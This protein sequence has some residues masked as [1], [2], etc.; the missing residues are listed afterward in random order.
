MA[1]TKGIQQIP[2]DLE[3][4]KREIAKQEQPK[5]KIVKFNTSLLNTN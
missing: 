1:Q 3:A 4:L 2:L 5:T